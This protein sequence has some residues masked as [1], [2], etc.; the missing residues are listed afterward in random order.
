V[1][2]EATANECQRAHPLS[3]CKYFARQPSLTDTGLA[4]QQDHSPTA[5]GDRLENGHH[6]A[7]LSVS[8]DQSLVGA[9]HCIHPAGTDSAVGCRVVAR[10]NDA[11]GGSE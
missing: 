8:G 10:F 7:Q 11:A 3:A 5:S 9:A 1:L 2:F 6:A 4:V